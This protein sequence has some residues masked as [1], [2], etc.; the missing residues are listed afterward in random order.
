MEQILLH[1]YDSIDAGFSYR[2]KKM[3]CIDDL[4][5]SS[6]WKKANKKEVQKSFENLKK[7][8]LVIEK[9]KT[10]DS[11]AIYLSDKGKLRALNLRF[12]QL[13]RNG[14]RNWDGKWRMVFFSIPERCRKGRDAL[15]YRLR[16]AGFYELQE[17]VF[18]FPY[19]CEKEIKDFIKLFKMEKYIR[20]ALLDFVYGSEHIAELF[21]LK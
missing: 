10:N 6:N 2:A 17:S 21:K 7:S 18:I 15:R 3:F 13:S 20:F 11:V 9:D 1:L 8:K 5:L 16:T 12:R 4:F 19:D 14:K